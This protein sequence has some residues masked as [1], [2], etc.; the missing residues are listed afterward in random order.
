MADRLVGKA[1]RA[2]PPDGCNFPSFAIGSCMF[3][4]WMS[5][6]VWIQEGK[7]YWKPDLLELLLGVPGVAVLEQKLQHQQIM[8]VLITVLEA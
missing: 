8:K 6:T 4:Q 5:F 2:T 3:V 1:A 7:N